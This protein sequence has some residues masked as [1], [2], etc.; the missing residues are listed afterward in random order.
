[1]KIENLQKG[2]Y[3][4][5]KILLREDNNEVKQNRLC[6]PF[7]LHTHISIMLKWGPIYVKISGN[8]YII[9]PAVLSQLI[10]GSFKLHHMSIFILNVYFIGQNDQV[11]G[12]GQVFGYI[13]CKLNCVW[14]SSSI[15][16]FYDIPAT[17]PRTPKKLNKTMVRWYFYW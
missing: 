4:I 14:E 2:I 11:I 5:K 7:Y 12:I 10:I 3:V 13:H 16:Q 17:A 8:K 1:M 6:Q 9:W 15:K